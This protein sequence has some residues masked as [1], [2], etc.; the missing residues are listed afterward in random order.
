MRNKRKEEKECRA[1]MS[2]RVGK[3]RENVRKGVGGRGIEGRRVSY[4]CQN[5]VVLLLAPVCCI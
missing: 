1:D 5:L 4:V 3:E 2:Q